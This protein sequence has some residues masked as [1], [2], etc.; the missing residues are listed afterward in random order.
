MGRGS[1]YPSRYGECA[2]MRARV[3]RVYRV[4]VCQVF[5]D[6]FS[7]LPGRVSKIGAKGLGL[8]EF[9]YESASPGPQGRG[10]SRPEGVKAAGQVGRGRVVDFLGGN[11]LQ[12]AEQHAARL[13]ECQE[14]SEYPDI[15]VPGKQGGVDV[16][17]HGAS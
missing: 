13:E 16:S 1:F 3:S 15:E 11:G 12:G 2:C 6:F 4:S 17:D 8:A 9:F 10:G 14:A 5:L 7:S